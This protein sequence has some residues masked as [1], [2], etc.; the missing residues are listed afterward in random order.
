MLFRSRGLRC[1]FGGDRVVCVGRRPELRSC[2]D[3]SFRGFDR[4]PKCP[5]P[6]GPRC[7]FGGDRL[8]CVGRRLELRGCGDISFRGFDGGPKCPA[9]SGP[10]CGLGGDR[11]VC[12]GGRVGL[13]GYRRNWRGPLGLDFGFWVESVQ[14]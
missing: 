3:I 10:R 7:G 8:V 12:G 1:G 14:L 5:A 11:L 6:S 9:P 4:G 13:K 2:G